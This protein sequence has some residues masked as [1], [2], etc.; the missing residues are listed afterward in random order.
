MDANAS[1]SAS[2][3][4]GRISSD[5][6]EAFKVKGKVV[7]ERFVDSIV[8]MTL[9]AMVGEG[10]NCAHERPKDFCPQDQ[11]VLWGPTTPYLN[12]HVLS[13]LNL[14]SDAVFSVGRK[15]RK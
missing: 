5:Y 15:V 4:D 10:H 12:I 13:K 9:D 11:N 6:M 14:I 3:V 1:I 8:V 7:K 2:F